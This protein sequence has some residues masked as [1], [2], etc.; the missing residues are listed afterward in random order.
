MK[1]DLPVVQTPAPQTKKSKGFLEW[2]LWLTPLV[3]LFLALLGYGVSFSVQ[4]VLGIPHA[5]AFESAFDL[6][7]L[8]SIAFIHIMPMAGQAFANALNPANIGALYEN[9][10]WYLV[11]VVP[12]ITFFF[13]VTWKRRHLRMKVK[14]LASDETAKRS[15]SAPLKQFAWLGL[16]AVLLPVAHIPLLYLLMVFCSG[17]AVFPAIG[18][19]IGEAYIKNWVI[20]PGQCAPVRNQ[21][22]GASVA[23]PKQNGA[24]C[25][26]VQKEDEEFAVFGRVVYAT[27]KSIILYDPQTQLTKRVSIT[28]AVVQSVDQI[29]EKTKPQNDKQ[30]NHHAQ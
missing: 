2:L 12:M 8:S 16:I 3:S 1:K 21:K 18:M 25:V 29:P 24:K 10:L 19:K 11:A 7:D 23:D 17:F 14:R 6:L 13:W 26:S 27:S 15:P 5:M 22:L 9:A 30:N 4:T 28:D 20:E